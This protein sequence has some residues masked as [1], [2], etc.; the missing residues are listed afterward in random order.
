MRPPQPLGRDIVSAI[1]RMKERDRVAGR[2]TCIDC[3]ACGA[4]TCLSFAE[5]V[6]R[7]AADE[8]DCVFVRQQQLLDRIAQLSERAE[9]RA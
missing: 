7:G 5:D 2:L 9:G 6:V 4:P 1:A 3:G 8:A